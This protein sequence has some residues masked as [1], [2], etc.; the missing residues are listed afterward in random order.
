MIDRDRGP[1]GRPMTVPPADARK[2]AALVNS[3]VE[4]RPH[5]R[6]SP[7]SCLNSTG[8][9]TATIRHTH[10]DTVVT[11]SGKRDDVGKIV[12]EHGFRYS[13]EV[14]IHL[15]GSPRVVAGGAALDDLVER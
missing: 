3:S 15:R 5:P 4:A 10:A 7:S 13:R 12:R 14:G 8:T 9:P 6:T 1:R 11:G 2:A